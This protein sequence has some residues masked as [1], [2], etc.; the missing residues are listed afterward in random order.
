LLIHLYIKFYKSSIRK[1][2]IFL[3]FIKDIFLP[4]RLPCPARGAFAKLPSTIPPPNFHAGIL[5]RLLLSLL[6]LRFSFFGLLEE[7]SD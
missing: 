3:S 6:T 7:L 2:F 5:W 1:H 4:R